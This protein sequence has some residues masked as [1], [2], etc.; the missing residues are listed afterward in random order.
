MER[1]F[2]TFEFECWNRGSFINYMTTERKNSNVDNRNGMDIVFFFCCF[3]FEFHPK[4]KNFLI[5][6]C[7]F[8]V[9]QSNFFLDIRQNKKEKMCAIKN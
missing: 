8:V 1:I 6:F 3:A 9:F 5:F 7:L 4:N 2:E